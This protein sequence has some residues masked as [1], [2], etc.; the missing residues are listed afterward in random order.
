VCFEDL[1][2]AHAYLTEIS[3]AVPQV[4]RGTTWFS[5][6]RDTFSE[7]NTKRTTSFSY[8]MHWGSH[9]PETFGVKQWSG[10]LTRVEADPVPLSVIVNDQPVELPTLHAK[11]ELGGVE[12]EIYVLDDAQ[13]P[14]VLDFRMALSRF[15]LRVI[16]ISFSPSE[17]QQPQIE[18]SLAEAGKAEVYGIYFDFKSAEIRGESEPVLKEIADVM[19]KNQSWNLSV[20]GHTDN[21]GGNAFNQDLS[22]RR[23]AAVR[24]ALVERYHIAAGRLTTTGFGAGHPKESNETIEGRA[25]NRRVELVRQ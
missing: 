11:G 8:M 24:Q 2:T 6:S 19:T 17:T 10:T 14:I 18:R 16:K 4:V 21:I 22:E 15:R 13:N 9:G 20:E 1:K 3:E 23:A 7:L 12:T 25:R 5:I